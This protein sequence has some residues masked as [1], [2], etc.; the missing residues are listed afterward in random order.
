MIFGDKEVAITRRLETANRWPE[1]YLSFIFDKN[2]LIPKSLNKAYVMH[3]STSTRA[4]ETSN[5]MLTTD[6]DFAK[7]HIFLVRKF[8]CEYRR[9]FL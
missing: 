8:L 6:I 4:E 7:L 2:P 5:L 1:S 3:L 9:D